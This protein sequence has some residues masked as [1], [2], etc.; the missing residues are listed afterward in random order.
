M[1]Q[2]MADLLHLFFQL[3]ELFICFFD[4]KAGDAAHRLLDQFFIV[5]RKDL[6]VKLLKKG[7]KKLVQDGGDNLQATSALVTRILV[8][9]L[10]DKDPQRSEEHTSELQ[11]LMR[12]SYAD[13]YLKK[14]K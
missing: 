14:N 4:V 6:P 5:L 2:V 3:P 9:A 11:S 8:H 12:I 7:L 10:T 13:F 1:T